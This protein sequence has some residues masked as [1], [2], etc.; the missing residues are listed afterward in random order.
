MNDESI[1]QWGIHKG[2]KMKDIPDSYLLYM[3][4]NNKCDFQVEKYIKEFLYNKI[5]INKNKK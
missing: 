2:K 3:Y 5:V 1:M 4:N